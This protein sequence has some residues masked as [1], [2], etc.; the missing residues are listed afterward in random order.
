[1]ASRLISGDE[2][3]RVRVPGRGGDGA[4]APPGDEDGRGRA[5]RAARIAVF[6]TGIDEISHIVKHD[7]FLRLF[8]WWS[9]G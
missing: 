7:S 4:D 8:I 3:R 1:M 6:R 5:G 2:G 9:F